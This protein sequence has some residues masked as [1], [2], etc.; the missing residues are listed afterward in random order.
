[1]LNNVI[2]I[3]RLV[4]KPEIK[5]LEDGTQVSNIRLAVMRPFRNADGEFETD[6]IPV[7]L[8]HGAAEIANDYCDK[9]DI[10]GIKG[11]VTQRVTE[12]NGINIHLTEI[13]GERIILIH[14]NYNK[15]GYF[16]GKNIVESK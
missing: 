10:I 7:S 14:T 16:G 11:R 15:E 13:V 1:M 12:Q 9:G 8:W 6:F 4:A 2:L 5:T 3:G